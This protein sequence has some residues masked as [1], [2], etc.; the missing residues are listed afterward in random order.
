MKEITQTRAQLEKRRDEINAQLNKVNQREEIR[1]DNDMEQQ[2]IEMEQH[3]VSVT[4]EEN[5]QK[6]LDSI[7]EKL[8]AINAE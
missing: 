7:E 3:E 6:E 5:L 2:A 8:A 1:L 4:M